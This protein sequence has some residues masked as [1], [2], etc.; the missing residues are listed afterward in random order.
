MGP[1]R[2]ASLTRAD[3]TGFSE[4]KQYGGH[5]QVLRYDGILNRSWLAE[6]SVA[7]S[8]NTIEEVPQI[9]EW[10]VSNRTVTPNAI[11]GGIG[12][13][14]QGNTSENTQYGVRFTNLFDAGGR[15]QIRY[16]GSFEDI[17]YAQ[18]N[19]RTGPT[20]VLPNGQQTATGAQIQILSDPVYGRIYRVTR[21]NLNTE[22]TTTQHYL[23]FFLQDTWDV[24]KHLTIKPG[25]RYEQQKIVGLLDDLTLDGNWAPRIGIVYDPQGNGKAKIY[26]N[27]GRFYA[28]IP[29]DLAARALSADDGVSRADYF[30]AN[31]TQP[32][33]E[34]TPAANTTIHFVR[35]GQFPDFVDRT[36]K[37]TYTNEILA[38]VE[39]EVAR[40][41]NVGARYIYRNIPRAL[42]DVGVDANNNAVTLYQ[43]VNDPDVAANLNY[44]LTNPS[45]GRPVVS[46]PGVAYESP[47]HKYHAV[48][49][50]ANKTFSDDWAL[51]A[52]YRWSRLSGTFEGFFRNDNGQSDPGITS[53]FDFPTNDPTYTALG[54]EQGFRGDIRYLGQLGEGPLPNDREHQFKVYGT[55]N[56]KDLNVGIGFFAS[57]GQPLT[58]LAA[59]PGYE[60]GG[61]IPEGPRGSGILTTDGFKT[62]TPWEWTM[63]LHA[64]YP[65]KLNQGRQRVVLIADVFNVTNRQ[66]PTNYDNWTE[67]T[68]GA[69]NPNYGQPTNGGGVLSTGYQAPRRFRL[70]ARFEW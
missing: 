27:Y 19:Q 45:P 30:D 40:N 58:A 50:T 6:A 9:D 22:R 14:E 7:H 38:G 4:L 34:G 35:S 59:M 62:R 70:G 24:G 3:L 28:Q 33:P 23:N 64:D 17:K 36:S 37:S 52:S 63:D 57:S 61:E 11:S 51:T 46:V 68:F 56:F 20:F 12:F 18:M 39:L 54:A 43:Y 49:L 53:L 41:L 15:H 2:L 10:S 47:I 1:Q 67:I 60:N 31:L 65:L 55:R 26:A 5:Q 44:L 42:E 69:V 29:N 25:V 21:A 48:E 16:G 32:V 66:E 13:Y 8:K